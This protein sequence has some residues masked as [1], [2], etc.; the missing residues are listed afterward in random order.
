MRIGVG[1]LFV[2][3]NC[4]ICAQTFVIRDKIVEQYSQENISY[5]MHY[6]DKSN[7]EDSLAVRYWTHAN[8]SSDL[9]LSNSH[10]LL[11]RVD[12]QTIPI[13]YTLSNERARYTSGVDELNSFNGLEYLT[14]NKMI[15]AVVDGDVA[16][17]KHIEFVDSNNESRVRTGDVQF[18][19]YP[20]DVFLKKKR[21]ESKIHATH[22]TGTIIAKGINPKAKG[23]APEAKVLSYNWQND[24][25]KIANIAKEGILVS[26]HSYGI[27]VLDNLGNPILPNYYFGTYNRDAHDFDRLCNLFPYFT[28]VI[29]AGNDY[30]SADIINP[31]MKGAVLLVGYTTAKNPIVVGAIEVAEYVGN[32]VMTSFSSTGPT[33]DFRIKPD[34]VTDGVAILSTGFST[35]LFEGAPFHRNV[36][37][38][39]SGTS[40]AAPVVTGVLTLWQQWAIEN[41]DFPLKAATL[42][43]IMIHTAN[44]VEKYEG[45]SYRYGWGRINA[46]SGIRLLE[47]SLKSKALVLE[48]L[49]LNQQISK[50]LVKL[51]TI[52]DKLIFTLVW[53]DPEGSDRVGN[54]MN[55]QKKD[56]VNDLDI[57]VFKDGVE[58]KPWRLNKDFM[59]LYP[60]K[61]DNDVDN[62]EKVE[63]D[64]PER[65]EYEVV[66]S[67]KNNLTR[68]VQDFSLVVS[69]NSYGGLEEKIGM[70]SFEHSTEI[71]PNPV[72]DFFYIELEKEYVFGSGMI[73]LY[74]INGRLV[75]S[76]E[77]AST[78]RAIVDISNFERGVYFVYYEING[79]EYSKKVLK[80]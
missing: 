49:L 78:N 68:K 67:H 6:M 32:D 54:G 29:A 20:T 8:A 74:D 55:M 40:M 53:T 76:V 9:L 52:A 80:K 63:I 43:A 33:N 66:I 26:N 46:Y 44:K 65:G 45:P 64:N 11:K 39:L 17:D 24:V 42:K 3:V 50:H 5:F 62:V 75:K 41:N 27:A 69:D 19:L 31:A 58:Y 56:L 79:Q 2:F 15:V 59:N 30:A 16:F 57:R 38:R 48:S 34:I 12:N 60:E 1:V 28:P 18:D 37:T 35:P 71:W 47:N 13:Y 70:A 77:V 21:E 7:L 36:Y 51:N 25:K 23:M 72:E 22:V 10:A 4:A 14:G 61:G 73:R